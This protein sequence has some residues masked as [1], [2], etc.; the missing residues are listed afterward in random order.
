[1]ALCTWGHIKISGVKGVTSRE[2]LRNHAFTDNSFKNSL[3]PEK[4]GEIIVV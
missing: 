4:E 2:D 3:C 1:M